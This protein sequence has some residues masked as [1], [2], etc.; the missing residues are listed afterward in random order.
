[1]S[2]NSVGNAPYSWNIDSTGY[3]QT[4]SRRSINC[5]SPI[6]VNQSE[7]NFRNKRILHQE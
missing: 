7:E 2:R 3:C 5:W 6:D 4:S 1:V